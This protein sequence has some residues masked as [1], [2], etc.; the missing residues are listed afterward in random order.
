MRGL[1][2]ALDANVDAGSQA[3]EEIDERRSGQRAQAAGGRSRRL[4]LSAVNNVDDIL[5]TGN[6]KST[7]SNLLSNLNSH[8]TMK[9]LG[10]ARHFLGISIQY[11]QDK[12]FLSQPAYAY[13]LLQQANLTNCNSLANPSCTKT[14]NSFLTGQYTRGPYN[15]QRTHRSSSIPHYNS[16]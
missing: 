16:A 5:I 9:H 13:S 6:D 3:E 1:D 10:L 4:R 12:Y 8:F 14:A 11:L 2:R 7:I 15:I